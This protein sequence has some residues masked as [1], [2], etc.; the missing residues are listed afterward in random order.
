LSILLIFLGVV[1]LHVYRYF[2]IDFRTYT[3]NEEIFPEEVG[4]ENLNVVFILY[5][6]T[7]IDG[8][9]YKYINSATIISITPN[10]KALFQLHPNTILSGG[11]SLK[12]GLNKF[13]ES[14]DFLL[15]DLV[16]NLEFT[17]G[18]R[19]DRYIVADSDKLVSFLGVED[20]KFEE[21][22]HKEDLLEEDLE[23]QINYVKYIVQNKLGF[24]NR[25]RYLLNSSALVDVI[26]TNFDRSEMISFTKILSSDKRLVEDYSR[27]SFIEESTVN[28]YALN[29]I[30]LDDFLKGYLRSIEVVSEQ[31]QLEVYNSTDIPGL[32]SAKSREF[33]NAGIKI[34]AKG[35]YFEPVDENL[36]FVTSEEDLVKY[37]NTIEVIKLSLNNNL[38]II[39]NDY[40]YNKTA[41]LILVLGDGRTF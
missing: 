39:I 12:F 31:S 18:I 15:K 29:E 10:R 13:E 1:L 2:Q 38:R 6:E 4:S 37:K 30:I 7:E 34:L 21:T 16:T 11:R 9:I 32:A 36:L 22:L 19:I 41:D 14:S 17:Y 28:G 8:F 27:D 5:N 40:K 20:K 26:F 3:T 33:S 24:T 25:Y 35:N 23:T